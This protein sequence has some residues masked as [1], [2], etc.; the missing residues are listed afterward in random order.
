LFAYILIRSFEAGL[1]RHIAHFIH[2]ELNESIGD[3]V[4]FLNQFHPLVLLAGFTGVEEDR[5]KERRVLRSS[6]ATDAEL[7]SAPT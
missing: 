4:G 7:Q 5:E 1:G 2:F 3:L 6:C